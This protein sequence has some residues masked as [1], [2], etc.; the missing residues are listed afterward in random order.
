MGH[1]SP[2]VNC[3]AMEKLMPDEQ[4]VQLLIDNF[5]MTRNDNCNCILECTSTDV[6]ADIG[7]TW[8]RSKMSQQGS[9]LPRDAM[10]QRY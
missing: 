9:F 10:H 5:R 7:F 6:S 1:P 4:N 8:A 3:H 2:K